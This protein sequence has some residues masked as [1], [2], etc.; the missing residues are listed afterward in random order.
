M[1]AA[2]LLSTAPVRA[3]SDLG[4]LFDTPQGALAYWAFDPTEFAGGNGPQRMLV[5]G[6]MRA[7]LASGIMGDTDAAEALSAILAASVVGTAPHRVC[8]TRFAATMAPSEGAD[9]WRLT[10][11]G[12]VLEVR[13]D[14]D[15][16][17]LMRTIQSILVDGPQA[18]DPDVAAP[19]QR[20]IDLPQGRT[21]MAFTRQGWAPWMEV[22]WVSLGDVFVVALGRGVLA[23]WLGR[24]RAGD[25]EDASEFP[26]VPHRR[27]VDLHHLGR[28][29]AI[30]EVF[31][32]IDALRRGFPGSF[33]EGRLGPLFDSWG[34]SNGRNFML[35]ARR[36][37]PADVR[38]TGL[39][40]ALE[41]TGPP[42]IA[43]DATWTARSRTRTEVEQ[44]PLALSDWPGREVRHD[45]PP[46][47]YAI[48]AQVDWSR[49]VDLGVS[50]YR[51]W[52]R[53]T[54]RAEF[55]ERRR[56]WMRQHQ[57]DLDRVVRSMDDWMV[58]SDVP[59]PPLPVPGM[60]SL[61]VELRPAVSRARFASALQGVLAS[62]GDR[63]VYDAE[64][65]IWSFRLLDADVDPAGALRALAWGLA[66]TSR[67]PVVVGGWGPIVVEENRE[68]LLREQ[69]NR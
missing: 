34:L 49:A 1:V 55:D 57:R 44:M 59:S 42:L 64:R 3:Q 4:G 8:V 33:S 67:S 46:G 13:S 20:E 61:F 22:S 14:R 31:L 2:A 54:D 62:L 32:D 26:W 58:L 12:A 29:E 21:G 30:L 16:R 5:E 10:D 19:R 28:G 39:R 35:H 25:I 68:R 9:A 69:R 50:T 48:V 47:T 7:A 45:P 51:L 17:T 40:A 37:A 52:R 27:R 36:V 53:E 66:G 11:L 23:D 56:T 18:L 43:I 41:Y 6:A 63:T 65:E 15:H 38:V 24:G 60:T